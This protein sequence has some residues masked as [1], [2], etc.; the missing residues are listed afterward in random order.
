MGT[1]CPV[2]NR[3]SLE[4]SLKIQEGRPCLQARMT[5]WVGGCKGKNPS[6]FLMAACRVN[7]VKSSHPWLEGETTFREKGV[8]EQVP[9]LSPRLRDKEVPSKLPRL[10][11]ST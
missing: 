7:T 2:L 3:M 5:V 10:R 4:W 8:T 11:K 9:R 6:R 1:A